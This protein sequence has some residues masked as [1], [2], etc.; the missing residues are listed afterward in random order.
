MGERLPYPS[1]LERREE[2]PC[3]LEKGWEGSW[4]LTGTFWNVKTSLQGPAKPSVSGLH[5]HEM[6][7][8][9]GLLP[10]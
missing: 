7:P 3:S 9:A 2:N 4:I 6:S 8:R 1:S 5:N 10:F